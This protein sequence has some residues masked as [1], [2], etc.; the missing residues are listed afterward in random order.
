MT[1]ALQSR[2]CYFRHRWSE[3]EGSVS[4]E[5]I[6]ALLGAAVW[7]WWGSE[8]IGVWAEGLT[9][10]NQAFLFNLTFVL[11]VRVVPSWKSMWKKQDKGTKNIFSQVWVLLNLRKW[12]TLLGSCLPLP[13]CSKTELISALYIFF[14]IHRIHMYM[15][16]RYTCNPSQSKS[17]TETGINIKCFQCSFDSHLIFHKQLV[18]KTG[19]KKMLNIK[20]FS[21]PPFLMKCRCVWCV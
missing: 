11:R 6:Q 19:S 10:I 1:K 4:E 15:D 12:L 17:I 3:D 8:V 14:H 21:F 7:E 5:W 20:W 13:L 16:L 18:W 9:L 2:S